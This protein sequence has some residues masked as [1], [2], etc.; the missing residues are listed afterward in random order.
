[1]SRSTVILSADRCGP[2]GLWVEGIDEVIALVLVMCYNHGNDKDRK[3][4]R[5]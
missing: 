5:I 4:I 1:M 2:G 3:Y